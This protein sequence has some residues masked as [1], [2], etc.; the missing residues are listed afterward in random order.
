MFPPKGWQSKGD[1]QV[2]TLI[3]TNT[4]RRLFQRKKVDFSYFRNC[5]STGIE[6][7]TVNLQNF[8]PNPHTRWRSLFLA[9]PRTSGVRVAVYCLLLDLFRDK[10]LWSL[11]R[12]YFGRACPP[13]NAEDLFR[14]LCGTLVAGGEGN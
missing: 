6:P 11:S 9:C 4:S 1:Y 5:P 12:I 7:L 8:K 10:G 3:L 13:L 14:S 2:P